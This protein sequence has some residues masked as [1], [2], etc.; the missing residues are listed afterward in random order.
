M[1]HPDRVL[2]LECPESYGTHRCSQLNKH[3][4]LHYCVCVKGE[5]KSW[6]TGELAPLSAFRP[7]LIKAE[8]VIELRQRGLV[9]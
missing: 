1:Y 7:D 9:K 8:H 2:K 4:G 5:Q 3:T 6:R